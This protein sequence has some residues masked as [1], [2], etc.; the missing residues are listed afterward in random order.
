MS[1]KELLYQEIEKLPDSFAPD[2]MDYIMFLENKL[3]KTELIRQVRTL[4][5]ASFSKIWD[6]EEDSIYD[7]L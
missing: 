7:T 6:N 3:K 2:I 5:E 1:V 4:S